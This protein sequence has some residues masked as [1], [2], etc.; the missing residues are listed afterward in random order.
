MQQVSK[1][2]VSTAIGSSVLAAAAQ[3]IGGTGGQFDPAHCIAIYFF[4]VQA[5]V[6]TFAI[7]ILRC[8]QNANCE[9]RCVRLF[10]ILTIIVNVFLL[11]CVAWSGLPF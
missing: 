1:P 2:L 11:I 9:S 10:F 3:S 7:C 5:V 4:L 6:I 8:D